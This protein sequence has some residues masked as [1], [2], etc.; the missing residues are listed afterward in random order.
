MRALSCAL[1]PRAISIAI[2]G[3]AIDTK[4]IVDSETISP[5]VAA[6]VLAFAGALT[7]VLVICGIDVVAALA[8]AQTVF[9]L[10]ARRAAAA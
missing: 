7:V 6:T 2:V 4:Y 8:A 5:S 10:G 3:I 9:T 1:A